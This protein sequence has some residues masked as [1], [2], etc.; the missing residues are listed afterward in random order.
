MRGAIVLILILLV[1]GLASIAN[2]EKKKD[3]ELNIGESVVVWDRNITLVGSNKDS[4]LLCMN[5]QNVVVMEDKNFNGVVFDVKSKTDDYARFTVTVPDSDGICN[6]C[7]NEKCM[8]FKK[9]ECS[10]DK[11]CGDG[12]EC[13]ADRCENGK[14]VHEDSG[15]I[16]AG[17]STTSTTTVTAVTGSNSITGSTTA[18]KENNG[19]KIATFGLLGVFIILI[20][21]ALLYKGKSKN[22]AVPRNS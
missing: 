2:A 18:G 21:V 19:F 15:C 10:L 9:P 4:F 20:V 13:T 7:S 17:T 8:S 12:I 3:V 16:N 22:L 11:D 14:C 5:G 1:L 6:E